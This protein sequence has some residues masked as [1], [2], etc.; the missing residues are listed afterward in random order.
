MYGGHS[1]QFAWHT[2]SLCLLS[3]YNFDKCLF[4]SL[5]H[6]SLDNKLHGHRPLGH[7]TGPQGSEMSQVKALSNTV[8]PGSIYAGRGGKAEAVVWVGSWRWSPLL[9]SPLLLQALFYQCDF[10][11][12]FDCNLE[13]LLSLSGFREKNMKVRVLFPPLSAKSPTH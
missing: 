3:W 13:G 10:I 6:F 7:S 5:K 1:S 4:N 8:Q 11:I 9:S 12:I 2:L